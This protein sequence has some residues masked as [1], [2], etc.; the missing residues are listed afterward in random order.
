MPA[1]VGVIHSMPKV[2]FEAGELER[3]GVKP[4][5]E[6]AMIEGLRSLQF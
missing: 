1:T 5:R 6:N 2:G 3:D 4:R